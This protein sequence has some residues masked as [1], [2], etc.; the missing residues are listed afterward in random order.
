[1][2]LSPETRLILRSERAKPSK[3]PKKRQI[4]AGA[5]YERRLDCRVHSTRLAAFFRSYITVRHFNRC[6]HAGLIA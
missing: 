3:S 6:H 5:I 1:M 2:Y 4:L